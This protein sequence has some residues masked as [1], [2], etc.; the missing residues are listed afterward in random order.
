RVDVYNWGDNHTIEGRPEDF[1]FVQAARHYLPS[2][3]AEI[4]RLRAAVDE[5]WQDGYGAG[6][7]AATR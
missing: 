4:R 2:L 1:A 7:N 6:V 3:I 5:A